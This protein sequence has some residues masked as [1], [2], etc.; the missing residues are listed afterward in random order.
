[1][2]ECVSKKK[3]VRLRIV[4]VFSGVCSL[5]SLIYYL[6]SGTDAVISIIS[7]FVVF[8]LSYGIFSLVYNFIKG[9]LG[10]LFGNGSVSKNTKIEVPYKEETFSA[11]GTHYYLKN[12]EKL[13]TGNPE[14]KKRGKT[15]AS[16]G[17]AGKRVY[18]YSYVNKPINLIQE[19]N[20]PHDHN[21]VMIQIAG[22]KVGY[23]SAEEALHVRDI[24]NHHTVRFISAFI[25]GGDYKEIFSD[26]A[27]EKHEGEPFVRV[28][29]GYK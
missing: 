5:L 14:W 17:Y 10:R 18:R 11:V 16:Q 27:F 1:M 8:G 24:L 9:F 20:N 29:I 25:G 22:E 28:K 13:A 23:I 12:I 21:A 4:I 26:G 3:S 6:S 15:L 19:N 7:A 2:D